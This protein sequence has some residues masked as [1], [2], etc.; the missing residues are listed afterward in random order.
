[1][2]NK[3]F[4]WQRYTNPIR[5]LFTG[6]MGYLE[7]MERPGSAA[8]T[9]SAVLN[10]RLGDYKTRPYRWF[11]TS[12]RNAAPWMVYHDFNLDDRLMF[13]IDGINYVDQASS[14][15]YKFDR[16]TPV[17]YEISVGD[18][19]RDDDPF[20]E[21]IRAIQAVSAIGSMAVGEGWLFG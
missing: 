17:T 21:G 18:D 2:D 6:D 14:I 3:L 16:T 11:K 1:M 12:I 15:R 13:E 20:A 8:Y 19:T 4:V 7:H 5:A 10:L 9:I